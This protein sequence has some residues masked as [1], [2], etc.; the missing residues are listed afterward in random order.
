MTKKQTK[1]MLRIAFIIASISSLAFVPW[2]IVWAWAAPLPDTVQEQV[3]DAIGYGLDGMIVYV[4]Q[5]GKE[6]AF[7]AAGWKDR[8]KKIPADPH[9]LFKVVFP[10][11]PIPPA[12]GK[13]HRKATKKR[14]S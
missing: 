4:D 2:V 9:S 1:Q 6:P 3:D 14:L 5:G 10:I 8:E 7:Y 12:I 13:I 11:L